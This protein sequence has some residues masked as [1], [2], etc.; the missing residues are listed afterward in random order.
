MS[1]LRG[2]ARQALAASRSIS[3]KMSGK[4][5]VASNLRATSTTSPKQKKLA[6]DYR[7]LFDSMGEEVLDLYEDIQEEIK[8]VMKRGVGEAVKSQFRAN[9]PLDRRYDPGAGI[10]RGPVYERTRK[11]LGVPIKYEVRSTGSFTSGNLP[12]VTLDIQMGKLQSDPNRPKRPYNW[13]S[14][15]SVTDSKKSAWKN[16]W[17]NRGEGASVI[18]YADALERGT[19]WFHNNPRTYTDSEGNK[20]KKGFHLFDRRVRIATEKSLEKVD[21]Q[22]AKLVKDFK[23]TSKIQ[24]SR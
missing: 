17:L 24:G 3:K 8:S 6:Q 10:S 23:F 9:T 14:Q 7:K 15:V 11:F 18:D 13:A 22:V 12:K 4:G 16:R 20:Y 1:G 19:K 5:F 21:E 2:K